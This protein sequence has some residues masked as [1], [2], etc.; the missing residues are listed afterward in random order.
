MLTTYLS[1]RAFCTAFNF[2]L[3]AFTSLYAAPTTTQEPRPS[4]S[5]QP[6]NQNYPAP[7]SKPHDADRY[8]GREEIAYVN[9]NEDRTLYER[10]L[11]LGD[12]DY[13]ENWRY[14][15]QAYYNGETQN[16]A[17][18][19]EH[20]GLRGI[21][22]DANP[23][24]THNYANYNYSN[25]YNYRNAPQEQVYY[26]NNYPYSSYNTAGNSNPYSSYNTS[27]Y[28]S[29]N[30]SSY[31][32]SESYPYNTTQTFDSGVRSNYTNPDSNVYPQYYNR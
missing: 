16:Q 21:G 1:K 17:Y 13:K 23:R 7:S 6:T 22:Y 25:R 26:Y 20:P 3:V 31:P 28:R 5:N 29:Y 12:W 4:S 11:R 2:A 18:D 14:D 27:G 15:K 32:Y 24:P 19:E 8:E 30:T 9:R 10:N